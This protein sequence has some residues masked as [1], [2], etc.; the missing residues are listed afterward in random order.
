M[1]VCGEPEQFIGYHRVGQDAQR[2]RHSCC[3]CFC[4]PCTLLEKPHQPNMQ[5]VNPF[6]DVFQ[7]IF[8]SRMAYTM[9][10]GLFGKETAHIVFELPEAVEL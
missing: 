9:L 2:S 6:F 8:S 1:Q 3:S 10:S 5:T 4:T 7:S